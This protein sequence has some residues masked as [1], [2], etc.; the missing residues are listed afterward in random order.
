M[1]ASDYISEQVLFECQG[2]P[3]QIRVRLTDPLPGIPLQALPAAEAGLVLRHIEEQT[4]LKAVRE[5]RKA[6][7]L[8]IETD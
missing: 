3:E 5:K 4:G 7:R 8:F 2:E 1:A 6:R